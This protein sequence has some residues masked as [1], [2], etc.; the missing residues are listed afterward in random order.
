MGFLTA[1]ANVKILIND[2]KN[3]EDFY[4]GKGYVEASVRQ[5]FI[6]KLFILLGWDVLH[7]EQKNP[8]EQEVKVEKPQR[9]EGMQSQKRADYAFSLAP[10][11]K[12][13]QFFVEAKKPARV[14]RKNK[15]DYFQ[16]AK[17]GWNSQTGISILTDFEE[18]VLVDCRFKPDFET[19]L[20]TEIKYY[21]YQEFLEEE[22]FAEFYFLFSREAVAEG[23]LRNYVEALPKPKTKGKQLKLFAG[24]YKAIDEDFLE[25][26]D[27]IRK[28]LAVAF[29]QNN[30]SLEDY[31]L[32]EA[33]Q[34]TIDRLVFMRFLEDKSIEP[35]DIIH[36]IAHAPFPWQKFVETCK[37]FDAKYNGIIFKNHFIDDDFEGA[38]E[39]LFRSICIDLDHTNT[40]YDFN[41][42]PIHILGNIYER[43]LGK[44][45]TIEDGKANIELKPEVRKAGGVFY[46]PKYIVDYIV[47]NTVGKLIAA[48]TPKQIAALT[49]ADIACGSG[50]FLIGV[51]EY[52]LDYHLKYYN[53]NINEAKKANCIYDPENQI[54][55]LSIKQKQQILTN[56]VFGVDID[57]Q[58]TEVTQVSLFLKLLEDETMATANDM[59]VLFAEK[60]LPDL[61][62]NIKCGN[63]LIGWEIM[64][65]QLF[66]QKELRKL[67]PFDFGQAFPKVFAKGGF[68]VIVGNPPYFSLTSLRD[69]ENIYLK[70]QY[71]VFDKSTD[72][73]CIFYEKSL[74]I[75]KENGIVSFITSNQWLQTNYGRIFR[76]YIRLKFNPYLLVNFGGFKVFK[77]ATVD[78]SIL[79][80]SKNKFVIL[81]GINFKN[82]FNLETNLTEYVE[83][84]SEKIFV[85][86]QK[87]DFS[88]ENSYN[89]KNKLKKLPKIKDSKLKINY[90]IKTGLNEAFIINEER[91]EELIKLDAKN[92]DIIKPL[93]R[94]RDSHKYFYK[95]AN[96]YLIVSKNGI[97]IKRDY[98]T[99]YNYLL[100][101]GDKIKCRSDQGENWWNL[102][103]C[104]Y[105]QL[106][107]TEKIIY[108]ETTVRRS[109]FT[110][111]EKEIFLDK[112]CFMITGNDLKYLNGILSSNL[113]EWF[114]ETE[115]RLL[116]KTSIQY[117]KQF[118]ENVPIP[119]ITPENQILHD[120]LVSLVEQ[121]LKAKQDEQHAKTA[122][123]KNIAERRCENLDSRINQIVY[124]LYD[125][126]REEIAL[127]EGR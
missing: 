88:N 11:Y 109:E 114:L 13:T 5:D 95:W 80:I 52:L 57:Q 122:M 3:N 51:Y 7:N 98:P 27:E 81:K 126:T 63:S 22:I 45:I 119:K 47:E 70:N 121:M 74:N 24:K 87:W 104:T 31:E 118:I 89:L 117:S 8:F 93:L 120:D 59:N 86:D 75:L 43:F 53:T 60:I 15:D 92:T 33:T 25:Y 101:F 71:K 76:N 41:Y 69:F 127:V 46:T 29:Y 48:K 4:L 90:G 103:A 125:L 73:Y 6:D 78:T 58:A 23:K 28:N 99:I 107:E 36:L 77:D 113:L 68:D 17:Y 30:P 115:L 106:F 38:D 102:R 54:Y 82:T 2:F 12:Q 44:V 65:G 34:R 83:K 56:N 20:Q 1:H 18:I 94:G 16:T 39:E 35:E 124:Q 72:I 123:D 19:I 10:N 67:N 105:Y 32:T 100:Q 108:P 21:N 84:N 14:L 61:S 85:S 49:F 64:D 116:G 26:I 97:N 96:L 110:Y 40:P 37:R 9:Q 62:G 111:V 91:K 42:F 55:V 50:S 79:Y 112:T 66:E